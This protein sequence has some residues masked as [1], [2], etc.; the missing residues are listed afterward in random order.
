M[1]FHRARV[2][3]LLEIAA[4][5]LQDEVPKGEAE[6]VRLSLM[7][8]RPYYKEIKLLSSSV[9]QRE[10]PYHSKPSITFV[11]STTV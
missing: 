8:R 9:L 2:P 4:R 1:N 10:M 11:L 6:R 7:T 5:F 3:T